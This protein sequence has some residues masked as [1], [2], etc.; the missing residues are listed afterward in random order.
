VESIAEFDLKNYNS[1]WKTF[2]REAVRVII[3][4]GTSI[5]M[6]KSGRIGYYKF[7]GGGKRRGETDVE[8]AMRETL[9]ETGLSLIEDTVKAFGSIRE[10]RKSNRRADEIFEQISYYYIAE[11]SDGV[12]PQ[13]LD[14]YEADEGY[15]LEWVE[16]EKALETN[17]FFGNRRR[18]A[19]LAREIF[20][21]EEILKSIKQ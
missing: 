18:F 11:A 2:F 21:L 12:L 1:E 14:V 10:K 5:A 15:S 6:V 9:E 8:T 20:V 16:I 3:V 13:K 19:F 7:P 4:K 17:R